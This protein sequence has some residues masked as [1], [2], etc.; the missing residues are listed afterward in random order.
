L[1]QPFKR[2]NSNRNLNC[3]RVKYK[4]RYRTQQQRLHKDHANKKYAST[5]RTDF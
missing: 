2:H 1:F 3:A 5:V 4:L